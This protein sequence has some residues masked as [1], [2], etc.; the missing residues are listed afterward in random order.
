MNLYALTG[1][2][3]SGIIRVRGEVRPQKSKPGSRDRG[4]FVFPNSRHSNR[5]A[6]TR[7]GMRGC[8]ATVTLIQ[9]EHLG[10]A[11]AACPCD[12]DRPLPIQGRQCR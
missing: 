2:R 7:Y 5:D 12:S 6:R 10:V 4:L 9:Q 3:I 1:V 8:R 11:E